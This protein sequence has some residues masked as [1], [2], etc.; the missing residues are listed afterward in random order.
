MFIGFADEHDLFVLT[1]SRSSIASLRTAR[2][3]TH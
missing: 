3:A 1:L 2:C